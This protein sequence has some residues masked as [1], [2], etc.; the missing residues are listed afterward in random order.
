MEEEIEVKHPRLCRFLDGVKNFATCFL[1]FM[2]G[3]IAG[4]VGVLILLNIG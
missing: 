2:L 4:A 3:L 1:C